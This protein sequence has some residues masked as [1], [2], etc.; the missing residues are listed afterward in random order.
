[1]SPSGIREIYAVPNQLQPDPPLQWKPLDASALSGTLANST[2]PVC[3]PC[4][5]SAVCQKITGSN[6]KPQV[7]AHRCHHGNI[8]TGLTTEVGQPVAWSAVSPV[9]MSP[10]A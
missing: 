4:I 5:S 9:L 2:I 3:V 7:G 1:M 8:S 10:Q 6:G